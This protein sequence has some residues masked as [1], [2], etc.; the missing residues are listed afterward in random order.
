MQY[1]RRAFLPQKYSIGLF[2]VNKS[3]N[4]RVLN[5]P[6]TNDKMPIARNSKFINPICLPLIHGN[7]HKLTI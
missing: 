1:I 2:I 3:N 4:I 6:P 5:Q 7:I